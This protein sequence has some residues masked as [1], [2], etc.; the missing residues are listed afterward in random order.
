LKKLEFDFLREESFVRLYL[1]LNYY[2]LFSLEL[3]S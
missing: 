3:N 2:G 1:S